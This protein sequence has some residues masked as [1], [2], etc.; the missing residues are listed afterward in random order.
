MNKINRLLSFAIALSFLTPL[1]SLAAHG[2]ADTGGGNGLN[3]VVLEGYQFNPRETTEYNT[4]LADINENLYKQSDTINLLKFYMYAHNKNWYLVPAKLDPISKPKLG[5]P[6]DAEQVGIQNKKEVFLQ[7]ETYEQASPIAKAK[8]ILHEMVMGMK[9]FTFLSPK[10][11]CLAIF[12]DFMSYKEASNSICETELDSIPVHHQ[13]TAKDYAEVRTLTNE[14]FERGSKIGAEAF[15]KILADNNF[16]P[17]TIVLDLK[18]IRD[19][20]YLK[21]ELI[22]QYLKDLENNSSRLLEYELIP[23]KDNLRQC[24]YSITL[25]ANDIVILK[26]QKG[27]DQVKN[28]EL[29]YAPDEH[30]VTAFRYK[31]YIL[32]SYATIPFQNSEEISQMSVGDSETSMDLIL[33]DDGKKVIGI[34]VYHKK[35]KSV[36]FDRKTNSNNS[37]S[38]KHISTTICRLPK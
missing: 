5:L 4:Y 21:K 14:L 8:L 32:D 29:S 19:P 38:L 1:A 26:N 36:E 15:V 17:S 7:K 33:S 10:D 28:L 34:E 30:R 37:V 25:S 18:K 23:K 6:F 24:P 16:I 11:Q 12:G 22:R 9:L 13:M 2:G 31:S 27:S 20:I 35:I 3:G